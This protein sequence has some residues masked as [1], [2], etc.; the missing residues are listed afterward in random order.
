MSLFF[1]VGNYTDLFAVT[2][3]LNSRIL[4]RFREEGIDIPYPITS[5]RI[6]KE[7]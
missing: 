2:D 3:R 4:S 6:E 5:V 1:W 7:P